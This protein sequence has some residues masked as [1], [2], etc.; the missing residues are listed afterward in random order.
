M[1]KGVGDFARAWL[2]LSPEFAVLGQF[3][4]SAG[5]TVD[6][7]PAESPWDAPNPDDLVVLSTNFAGY[8][9]LVL[10]QRLKNP[11]TGGCTV[12]LVDRE[13]NAEHVLPLAQYCMA[14]GFLFF[15]P[16]QQITGNEQI[17]SLFAG[18]ERPVPAESTDQ[19]LSRLEDRMGGGARDLADRVVAGLSSERTQHFLHSVTDEATGLFRGDYIAF[20]LEEEF[21]RSWRFRY[22]LSLV[23][24]DLPGLAADPARETTLSR[25][26]GVFLNQC[27][28]IDVVGR[29]D[30]SSFLLILPNTGSMGA[31][32][33]ANRILDCLR[34]DVAKQL[35]SA[36][37]IVTVPKTGVR[38]KDDLL[39]LAR[40]TMFQAWASS[41]E[42]RVQVAD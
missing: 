26:A 12:I 34:T 21:K 7:L 16:S 4:A 39:D 40:L 3:L 22:P 18:L 41:G 42:E 15:D 14:D 30:D 20:R 5:L 33:L 28:D 25:I 35:A 6:T 2:G 17:E 32:V 24:Y 11:H 19:I 9:A 10:C 37:A 27:R 38:T 29:Y 13:S 8:N 23:L 36:V 31:Q 1:S